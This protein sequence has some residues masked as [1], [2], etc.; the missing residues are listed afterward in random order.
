MDNKLKKKILTTIGIIALVSAS[1]ILI[2]N[3]KKL[4]FLMNRLTLIFIIL[5]FAGIYALYKLNKK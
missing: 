3:F 1:I 5:I 2:W 4:R